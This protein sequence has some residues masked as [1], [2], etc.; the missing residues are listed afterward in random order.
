[1]MRDLPGD[2]ISSY[3]GPGLDTR[4]LTNL[5]LASRENRELLENELESRR[6]HLDDTT[7]RVAVKHYLRNPREA[8]KIYGPISSWDVSRVT[9]MSSLFENAHRFN[10]DLSNWDVSRVTNM[11]RMFNYALSFNGDLSNWHVSRV[12]NMSNM[13]NRA[14]VFN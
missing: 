10:R 2:V 13:F 12:T 3:I 5:S 9:D 6:F 8:I 4:S 11:S 14:E 7:I 1:M